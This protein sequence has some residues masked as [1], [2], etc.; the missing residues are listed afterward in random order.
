MDL[1]FLFIKR[2][3]GLLPCIGYGQVYSLPWPGDAELSHA[4]PQ[5]A[6][7]QAKD[8]SRAGPAFHFP[9]RAIENADDVG[10][11]HLLDLLI[12]RA[13]GSQLQAGQMVNQ[14]EHR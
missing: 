6:W 12:D 10:A 5:G 8:C 7:V 3:R 4:P 14:F 13:I 1:S 9:S 2:I 11:L